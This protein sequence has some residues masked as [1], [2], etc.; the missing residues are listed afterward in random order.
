MPKRFPS[1]GQ[2]SLQATIIQPIREWVPWTPWVPYR[3]CWWAGWVVMLFIFST[4]CL[5]RGMPSPAITYTSLTMLGYYPWPFFFWKLAAIS[6]SSVYIYALIMNVS[7]IGGCITGWSCAFA[8]LCIRDLMAWGISSV[9]PLITTASCS[10]LPSLSQGLWLLVSQSGFLTSTQTLS[11]SRLHPPSFAKQHAMVSNLIC[12]YATL[13]AH[14]ESGRIVNNHTS[15]SIL[16][17]SS[18]FLT[19]ASASSW[20]LVA[21]QTVHSGDQSTTAAIHFPTLPQCVM[22]CSIMH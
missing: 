21:S 19:G 12:C 5:V 10:L 4:S 22:H 17:S 11:H 15:F 16:N 7:W 18:N 1:L 8:F 13:S 14:P 6:I 2:A 9:S 20:A 3:C